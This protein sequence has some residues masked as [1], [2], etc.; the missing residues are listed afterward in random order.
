ML[1]LLVFLYLSSASTVL[2][3]VSHSFKPLA[4]QLGKAECM[5]IIP[6]YTDAIGLQS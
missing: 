3:L 1:G 4:Y 6:V 5:L 2:K